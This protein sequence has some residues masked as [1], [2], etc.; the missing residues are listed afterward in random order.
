MKFAL[1]VLLLLSGCATGIKMTEEEA[2]VCKAET[3]TAWTE[4]QLN[5]MAHWFWRSGFMAGKGSI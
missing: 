5:Y 1:L 4:K 2:K 3:C